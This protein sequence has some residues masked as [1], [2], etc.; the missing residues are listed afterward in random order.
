[1]TYQPK[2]R[3]KAVE[4]KKGGRGVER[5]QRQV[6]MTPSAKEKKKKEP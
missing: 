5:V 1:M 2:K 3:P 4:R 6:R